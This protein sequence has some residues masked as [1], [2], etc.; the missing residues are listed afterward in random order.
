MTARARWSGVNPGPLWKLWDSFG[1]QD[2]TMIGWWEPHCPVETGNSDV[3]ATVY[4]KNGRALVAIASWAKAIT[5]VH[6]AIEW[7]KLGLDKQK[8]NIS[9]PSIEGMQ[10]AHNF[11]PDQPVSIHPG[12]GSLILIAES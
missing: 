12:K 2:S 4:Q 8:V 6:L 11:A 5:T 7:E 9:A 10:D 1:I 3:R